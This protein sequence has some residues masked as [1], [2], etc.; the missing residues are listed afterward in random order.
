MPV[1]R[2]SF[3]ERH[4]GGDWGSPFFFRCF[5]VVIPDWVLVENRADIFLTLWWGNGAPCDQ[6]GRQQKAEEMFTFSHE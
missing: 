4:E 6:K 5:G 2:F 3:D 1:R